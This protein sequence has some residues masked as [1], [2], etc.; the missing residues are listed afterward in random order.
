MP[1][2]FR[3]TRYGIEG[4]LTGSV[5]GTAS[6]AITASYVATASRAVSSSYAISA[7]RAISSSNS[8][9]ASRAVSSSYAV[10]ASSVPWAG[11]EGS[12]ASLASLSE[13]ILNYVSGNYTTASLVVKSE[14]VRNIIPI[15]SASY[16]ALINPDA[17][18]LYIITD[19]PTLKKPVV[20][21]ETDGTSG[22]LGLNSSSV[23]SNWQLQNLDFTPYRY[24][25]C[26]FRASA[27]SE[28]DSKRTPAVV[29][30][31][32]LEEASKGDANYYMGS[33]LVLHPFNRN[34]EYA[35]GVAVDSTKTKIQVVYQI[36]L[37]DVSTTDA[38]DGQRYLYKIVGYFD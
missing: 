21:Y 18:N 4:N 29:V 14:E 11:V 5:Q 33:T 2:S 35:V 23:S 9:S 36:T 10:S 27:T 16:S 34:R 8:I 3:V 25:K 6:Y 15:T 37:W 7:S 38:N 20:I 12:S 22:L 28:G 32:P 13:E 1:S 17:E 19:A 24:L 31:V 30:E 26:Y